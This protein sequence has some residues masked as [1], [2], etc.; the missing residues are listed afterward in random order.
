[1]KKWLSLLLFIPILSFSQDC[2]LKTE[3]DDFTHEKKITTGFANLNEAGDR[4]LLSVEANSKEIDFFFALPGKGDAGCFD[5]SS[6]AVINFE[7]TRVKATYRNTGSMNC[8]GLFHFT[9]RNVK[10]TPSALT[11]LATTKI[12]SINFKGNGKPFE[13]T[14]QESDKEVIM[15]MANCLI[16]ESKTL[17]K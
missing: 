2:K 15:A 12:S 17:I 14:V 3:T 5:N 9:F 10:T 11:R 8:E 6:T 4:F 1:M 13:I 7:G 16:N